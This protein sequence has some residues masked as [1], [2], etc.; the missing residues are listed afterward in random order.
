M[1]PETFDME[2]N[3]FQEKP[4]PTINFSP[5]IVNGNNNKTIQ[6]DPETPNH[7]VGGSSKELGTRSKDLLLN[8]S[9]SNDKDKPS[10]NN[11]HKPEKSS[12]GFGSGIIDFAKGFLVKK[13]D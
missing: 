11:K 3:G 6:E 12:G 1:N 7:I 2:R 13:K 4:G 8:L 9:D 5:I 10:D